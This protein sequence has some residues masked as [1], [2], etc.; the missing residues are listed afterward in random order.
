[1]HSYANPGAHAP[2]AYM[3][4]TYEFRMYIYFDSCAFEFL[5]L[6]GFVVKNNYKISE[7]SFPDRRALLSMHTSFHREYKSPLSCTLHCNITKKIIG[8][9]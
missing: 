4:A 5:G 6:L 1:M 9:F 3:C 8:I 2:L 7:H